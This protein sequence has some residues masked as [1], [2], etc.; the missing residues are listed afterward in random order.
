MNYF[1]PPHNGRPP[2]DTAIRAAS[3]LYC[4]D[5][6]RYR[7]E[8]AEGGHCY[9]VID[10]LAER[11]TRRIV[12]RGNYAQASRLVRDLNSPIGSA[13]PKDQGIARAK[14]S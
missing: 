12:S 8:L 14:R 11:P 4:A 10:Y 2:T 13:Q 6:A 7:A 3:R 9:E 1:T 5:K